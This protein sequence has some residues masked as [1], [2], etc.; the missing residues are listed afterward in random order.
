MARFDNP[1]PHGSTGPIN[2]AQ[3]K[4]LD[5][6]LRHLDNGVITCSQ[7]FAQ[8]EK[9]QRQRMTHLQVSRE[10]GAAPRDIA[11]SGRLRLSEV[12]I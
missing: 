1:S 11:E 3:V 12:G 5:Q 6:G 2:T 8:F 10:S 4:E 7:T 9:E